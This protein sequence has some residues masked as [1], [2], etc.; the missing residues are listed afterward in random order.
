MKR[1]IVLFLL[2]IFSVHGSSSFAQTPEAVECRVFNSVLKNWYEV[3][4]SIYPVKLIQTAQ[5]NHRNYCCKY[6][7]TVTPVAMDNY[8][9]ANKTDDYLDSPWLYDHLV[10][11][12][13]R[14]LDGVPDLQYDDTPTD[15]K[16]T[17]WREKITEVWSNP[18][19]T[20]P[21]SIMS[22]YKEYRWDRSK[23]PEIVQSQTQTCPDSVVRFVKYNEDRETLPLSQ[24]YFVI[25]E[26][27]SCMA[28]NEKNAH[29]S[30]CQNLALERT[31]QEDTYVQGVIV[32][33]GE[34]A[35]Q[36]S[37]NSY[38]RSYMNHNRLPALLEKIVTMAKWFWFVD[39]KVPEMTRMCSG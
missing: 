39:S 4:P 22:Q 10:D 23:G 20:I 28:S 37:F 35:I 36:T 2:M 24:K 6:H 34:Q 1:I 32:Y 12:G 8:C 38:A 29:L 16:G 11:V 17:E 14:Y 3:F 18:N 19:G 33:Q 27:S 5:K 21:L 30:F 26:L 25:C 31:I 15:R 9:L 13:F 7:S